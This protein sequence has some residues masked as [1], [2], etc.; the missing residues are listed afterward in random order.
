MPSGKGQPSPA[1]SKRLNVSRT[2]EAAMPSRR[3]ISRVEIPA[4]NFK[5]MISRTWRIA[6]LSAGMASSL[7][8]IAKGGTLNR[9]AEA[10]VA[11]PDPGRHYSVPVGGIISLWWA[12]SFRYG[13]R[14]HLVMMGGLDRNQHT[15]GERPC[16]GRIHHFSCSRAASGFA[17]TILVVESGDLVSRQIISTSASALAA[18]GP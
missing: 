11:I 13:G 15:T 18:N 5:R 7:P 2:V 6:T 16:L 12:A 8:W 17:L 14:H 3:A 9:P 1:P 10:L 4:E